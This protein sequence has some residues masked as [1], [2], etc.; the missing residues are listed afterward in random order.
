MNAIQIKRNADARNSPLGQ[1]GG[2]LSRR[3]WQILIVFVVIVAVVA[4]TTFHMPKQYEAR[5]KIFVKNERA[6]IVVSPG[7]SAQ[8]SPPGEVSE[9]ELNTEIELLS[10]Y[11]LLRQVVSATGLDKVQATGKNTPAEL[12]ELAI[13]NAVSN[14]RQ[15]LK[16][17]AARKAD[18]IDV[19][20]MAGTPRQAVAVLRQLSASYLESHLRVHGTPGTH[21]FFLSQAAHYRNE[22]KNAETKLTGFNLKND[23]VLFAQQKEEIVRRASESSSMLLAVEAGIREYTRRIADTRNQLGAVEPRVVT[24]RRTLFNQSSVEHLGT[25]LVELQNRRT[26][27]LSKYRADDRLVEEVSQEITDTQTALERAN[28][29]TGS[30]Q[31][32]DINPVRQTLELELTKE[33]T[34]LAGLEAKRQE[35]ARQTDNYRLRLSSFGV[36]TAEYD[37]LIRDQ[38]EA[39]DSYLLYERKAEE[40]RIAESLDQQKISNVSIL[41]HPVEPLLPS[42]PDVGMNLILGTVLAAFFSLGVAF[43]AEYLGQPFPRVEADSQLSIGPVSGNA[44]LIE[45]LDLETLTGLPVLA[46]TDFS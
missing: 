45:T 2:I 20:Y 1:I 30:D 34:E 37:D 43:S 9:T 5:M 11:D 38:K 41:E 44:P 36:S 40:A 28:N 8:S 3:K 39:E 35:L 23:I 6:N 32:T 33:Q 22:L 18:I 14:L 13:Q 27:L 16:I 7:T 29:L 46:V 10:S 42:K 31:A 25:M 26:Q 15:G 4:G 21:E 12:Q 19:V 17:S 24:Q